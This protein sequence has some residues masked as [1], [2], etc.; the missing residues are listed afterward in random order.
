MKYASRLL[1]IVACLVFLHDRFVEEQPARAH[2]LN[3]NTVFNLSFPE[4][5]QDIYLV[6]VG[7]PAY[8]EDEED[9]QVWSPLYPEEEDAYTRVPIMNDAVYYTYGPITD[10]LVFDYYN[11]EEV[12]METPFTWFPIESFSRWY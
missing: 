8:P 2:K 4:T 11:Y 5:K 12:E 9:F 6:N 1:T 10:D 3:G 7:Q